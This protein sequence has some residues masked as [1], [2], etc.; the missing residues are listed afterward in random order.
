M[1]KEN[2]LKRL[3]KMSSIINIPREYHRA[4]LGELAF[5]I[6][7]SIFI[8]SSLQDL[9]EPKKTEV[10]LG[11]FTIT[12]DDLKVVNDRL[13]RI[14]NFRKKRALLVLNFDS[15]GL[16]WEDRKRESSKLRYYLSRIM[17]HTTTIVITEGSSELSKLLTPLFGLREVH[18]RRVGELLEVKLDNLQTH[19]T[20]SG[21]EDNDPQSR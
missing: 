6:P 21:S 10:P 18:F 5:L 17:R 1:D 11:L 14:V 20:L 9:P 7:N 12:P 19:I 16:S 8:L 3:I 15:K 2:L 13:S 4:F